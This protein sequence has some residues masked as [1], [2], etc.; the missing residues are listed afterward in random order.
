[1]RFATLL[2][3]AYVLVGIP[4]IEVLAEQNQKSHNQSSDGDLY[5]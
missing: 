3:M 5:T 4:S 1:M 2:L